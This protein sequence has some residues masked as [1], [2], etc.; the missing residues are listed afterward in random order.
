MSAERTVTI[1]VDGQEISADHGRNL[2]EIL[3]DM[4]TDIPSFCYHSE[5]NRKLR[6]RLC[7]VEVDGEEELVMACTW[8][9]MEPIAVVTTSSRI[10]EA[11]K[12]NLQALFD[13]HYRPEACADCIWDGGCEIHALAERYGVW[14]DRP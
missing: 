8:T 7:L 14:E 6:C 11:R 10:D 2:L 1:V 5:G 4:K 9:V 13:A 12:R 3:R